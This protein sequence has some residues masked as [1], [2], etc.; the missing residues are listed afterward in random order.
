MTSPDYVIDLS[1]KPNKRWAEVAQKEKPVLRKLVNTI[2]GFVLSIPKPVFNIISGFY[3][4]RNAEYLREANAFADV[5]G[6]PRALIQAA[7][8]MY[9]LVHLV[10]KNSFKE[11]PRVGC[12]T[13]VAQQSVGGAYEMFRTLDWNLP[14][15]TDCTR[16][17]EFIN[18]KAG[19]YTGIGTVGSVGIL[20]AMHH[21]GRYCVA[22]NDAPP[23]HGLRTG[24]APSFQIRR[25]MEN[26]PTGVDA[27]AFLRKPRLATSAFFTLCEVDGAVLVEHTGRE[28]KVQAWPTRALVVTNHYQLFNSAEI[29]ASIDQNSLLRKAA[30]HEAIHRGDRFAAYTREPINMPITQYRARCVPEKLQLALF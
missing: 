1:K 14:G 11:V 5:L 4:L 28:V 24:A 15:M 2:K 7:Q 27:V 10:D 9:E 26:C 23:V 8:L 18:G 21:R 3:W 20:T 29:G 22:L 12:T 6:E 17:F 19:T 30:G 25:A 13:T 16:T